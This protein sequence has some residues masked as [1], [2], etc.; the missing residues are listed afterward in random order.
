VKTYNTSI[1]A[2]MT[3]ELLVAQMGIDDVQENLRN[4]G[5]ND[6]WGLM[7]W[8]NGS[9]L[10]SEEA[11]AVKGR[12]KHTDGSWLIYNT[13]NY[14]ENSMQVQKAYN[15]SQIL[16]IPDSIFTKRCAYT[17]DGYLPWAFS[18]FVKRGQ[19]MI[20][21]VATEITKPTHT[22]GRAIDDTQGDIK[23]EEI[24]GQSQLQ[25]LYNAGNISFG[26]IQDTFNNMADTFTLYIRENGNAN[27]ADPVQ[28]VVYHYATCVSVNW[29]WISLPVAL[30]LGAAILLV[31]TQNFTAS[32]V[33]PVWKS[34][35]L[36]L[37]YR[38]RLDDAGTDLNNGQDGTDGEGALGDAMKGMEEMAKATRVTLDH[39]TPKTKLLR[40]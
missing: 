31:V 39:S 6:F 12:V 3:T 22:K 1:A 32:G 2:G 20:G 25:M 33:I 13:T 9:C 7:V 19:F 36:P 16:D 4:D 34:P 10:T 15:I 26:L 14:M 28:G 24:Y 18:A 5:T 35:L 21:D 40:V 30:V 23:V 37:M 8:I 38:T 17:C 29:A 11:E 27:Y